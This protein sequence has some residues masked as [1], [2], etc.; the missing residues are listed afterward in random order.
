MN[1]DLPKTYIP[2]NIEKQL[3]DF[4]L[5]NKYFHADVKSRKKTYVISMPPP[6]ITGHLHM[7]WIKLY[8]IS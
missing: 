8:K 2:Q 4:W 6:N 7:L 3:Y 1:T 5:E